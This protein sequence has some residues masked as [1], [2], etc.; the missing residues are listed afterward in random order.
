MKMLSQHKVKNLP[1]GLDYKC[2]NENTSCQH[3][4]PVPTEKLTISHKARN[5]NILKKGF[6]PLILYVYFIIYFQ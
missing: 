2:K 6:I 1:Y 3:K 5:I 4:I